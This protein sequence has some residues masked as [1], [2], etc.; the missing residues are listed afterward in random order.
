[1]GK[2]KI[3]STGNAPVTKIEGAIWGGG[4]IQIEKNAE[5]K[6]APLA[7]NPN[8]ITPYYPAPPTG[9]V[10]DLI[11]SELTQLSINTG[12]ITRIPD[13]NIF[14]ID[15]INGI[16]Y[17]TIEA[18]A[19]DGQESALL[20][21]LISQGMINIINNGTGSLVITG[22]YPISKLL[23]LNLQITLLRYARPL[24]EPLTKVGITTSQGNV[25]MRSNLVRSGY[26]IGGSGVKVGVISDS[27]NTIRNNPALADVSNG[28]L[29]GITNPNGN[30]TPVQVLGGFPF[31]I[32]LDEGRA[33]AQIVHDVAPKAELA[34]RTGFISAGDFGQGIRELANAGCQVIVD[35]VTYITEP[36][37][38][39]G[40]V[41]QAVDEVDTQSE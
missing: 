31:G 5:I 40:V 11:G 15:T 36:F 41:A 12:P 21:Y 39:D 27:Y 16:P 9:K 13:N 7:F 22:L 34:F 28:D 30:L 23:D 32:R 25:A 33:M 37:Y 24:Y 20:A 1:M 6:Y 38:R 19:I 26:D 29:P 4:I 35:D 2:F 3:K 18:V 8:K 17:V 14:R 10:G